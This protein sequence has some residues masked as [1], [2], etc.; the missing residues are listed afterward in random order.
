VRR[1]DALAAELKREVPLL[2]KLSP[3]LSDAEL[4]QALEALTRARVDGVIATNTTLS[5]TGL[6]SPQAG[7]A[8][9]LSGA[10]LS[11]ASTAVV[12]RIHRETGG[13]LPIVASG[14]VCS[15]EDAQAKLDAGASL[16]Q[17]YTGLIYEGPG[18]VP[19]LVRELR[20]PDRARCG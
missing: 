17:V 16:V 18:L 7:E 1:R 9:G 12:R 14:G 19:R 13:R 6:S 10:A 3:D 11:R 15:V 4:D 20:A 5:R 2:V 8:G